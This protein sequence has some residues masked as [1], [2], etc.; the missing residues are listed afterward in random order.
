MRTL[1]VQNCA[2]YSVTQD[3][4]IKCY[5]DYWFD[6]ANQVCH[7]NPV[8]LLGCAQ[9]ATESTCAQCAGTF[10]LSNGTCLP[11]E[12]GKAQPGCVSYDSSQ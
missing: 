8:G 9:Y 10:Y 1:T 2:E 7:P 12:T 6:S 5:D 11:L 4:C 3:Q